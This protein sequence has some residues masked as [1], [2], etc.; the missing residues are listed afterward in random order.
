MIHRPSVLLVSSILVL[1]SQ[2]CL[3]NSGASSSSNVN[4]H[5]RGGGSSGDDDPSQITSFS[6]FR[7]PPCHFSSVGFGIETNGTSEGT[8]EATM[9]LTQTLLGRKEC[10]WF[11][12]KVHAGHNL[13]VLRSRC[14]A[15]FWGAV[16]L[17]TRHL[18][19][20]PDPHFCGMSRM[21]IK[22]KKKLE[23]VGGTEAM[24]KG[25]ARDMLDTFPP[26][27]EEIYRDEEGNLHI[28]KGLQL[29]F[30]CPAFLRCGKELK[31]PSEEEAS[32]ERLCPIVTAQVAA[33]AHE[34]SVFDSLDDYESHCNK[35]KEED[36][37]AI[38]F[39]D[40]SYMPPVMVEQKTQTDQAHPAP[41]CCLFVGHVLQA[42][43]RLNEYTGE[44]YYW[45]LVETIGDVKFDVV[46]HPDLVDNQSPPRRG[47]IVKGVFFLS[48][49]FCPD[50][51]E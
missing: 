14:G 36:E 3:G 37:E 34:V 24:F 8:I 23:W 2:A 35:Q 29:E 25:D 17:K 7:P 49:H 30:Q 26:E 44:I 16:D 50:E 19:A 43:E 42:E 10:H 48:A 18:V 12:S 31:V 20:G 51:E 45:A 5:H 33:F 21:K 22:V 27:E 15:E 6:L 39:S 40:K 38:I 13:L 11:P 28:N 41:K 9:K 1:A 4:S 46:I 32:S 47:G